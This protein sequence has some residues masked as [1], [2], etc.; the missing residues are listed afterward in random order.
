MRRKI[1]SAADCQRTIIYRGA[2]MMDTKNYSEIIETFRKRLGAVPE[3]ITGIRP[4]QDS[5]SLREIIGHLVDS[6]S[7]NHQRFVRLQFGDLLG[8]PAYDG[9]GWIKVQNY[10]EMDWDSLVTLWYSYNLLL[11]HVIEN[12]DAGSL[13]NVWIKD[14]EALT[15]EYLVKDY[16]RHLQWHI[17]HFEGRLKEVEKMP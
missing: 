12:L 13:D 10:R 5:W 4:D 17:D 11:L 1:T 14:E 6:A 15:L 3:R 9:E 7:N 8:F 2:I 16:F